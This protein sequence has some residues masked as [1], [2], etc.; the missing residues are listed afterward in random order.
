MVPFGVGLCPALQLSVV[1]Q[2]LF[3]VSG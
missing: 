2:R 3:L 1:R